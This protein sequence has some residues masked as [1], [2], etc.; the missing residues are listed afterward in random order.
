MAKQ[1]KNQEKQRDGERIAKV[2]ARAGL[3]SRREAERWIEE[4]RVEMNGE[5][6]TTPA[7]LVSSA[8]KIM[9]DGKP[10]PVKEKTRIFLYHKPAGLMT[11][12]N[13]EKGRETIFDHFPNDLPRVVTVGRLDMNT[14]GL[15]LLTNDGE[16][17]RYLELPKNEFKRTYRVRAHG[18]I[19]QERLDQLESGIVWNKIKYDSIEATLEKQQG[20]NVWIEISLKEGKNREVRNIMEALGLTVNRLIRLSYGPFHLGRLPKKAI[21]EVKTHQ[22][23][24][25]VPE[26][27]T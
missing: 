13:D 27:F 24:K 11:T 20:A 5:I 21:M 16:L 4:A 17:S 2:M 1:E 23:K 19:S 22:L 6:V 25:M 8:D 10:L 3:C 9:V 15:L 14:E 26:F 18:K 12:N 7:T